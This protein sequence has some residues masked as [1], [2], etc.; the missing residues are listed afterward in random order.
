VTEHV[1]SGAQQEPFGCGQGFG[2]QV[3]RAPS[4]RLG[5]M[6]AVCVVTAQVPSRAQHDP[7][8]CGHGFGLQM[9]KSVQSSGQSDWIVTV[10]VPS[11]AQQEPVG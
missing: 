2:K 4:Q 11:A 5:A 10:H 7:D 1:P 6:H 9:A 3:V 8:G